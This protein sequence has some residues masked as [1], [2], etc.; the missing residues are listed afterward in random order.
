ME[1]LDLIELILLTP[2][3]TSHAQPTDQGVIQAL[4]AKYRS[5]TVR[6]LI[7][8]LEKKEPMPMISILSTMTVLTKSWHVFSLKT[9]TNCFKIAGISEKEV[10][11]V[12]RDD[13]D[14]S[15]GG[16]DDIEWGHP[17][18]TFAKYSEK[19]TFLTP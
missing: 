8:A 4:K 1:N 15:L 5:L 17:L 19:L 14:D 7:S 2:N 9:F 10:E 13:E 18:S 11:G 3:T 6:K 12:R 16:L